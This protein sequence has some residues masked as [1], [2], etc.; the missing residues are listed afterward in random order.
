MLGLVCT[1]SLGAQL[2]GP[3]VE[4][5]A[6]GVGV[7]QKN[8]GP[9][10][11]FRG[12][13]NHGYAVTGWLYA[14]VGLGMEYRN[15]VVNDAEP[16]SANPAEHIY[17]RHLELNQLE[18][19]ATAAL[20]VEAGKWSLESGVAYLQ[21]LRARATLTT[22]TYTAAGNELTQPTTRTLSYRTIPPQEYDGEYYFL[23]HSRWWGTLAVNTQIAPRLVVGLGYRRNLGRTTLVHTSD[24]EC[25]RE[26]FCSRI[27]TFRREI[28]AATGTLTLSLRYSLGTR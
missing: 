27:G 3:D 23:L 18:G 7:F 10:P 22:G 11:A 8:P 12:T 17:R 16:S 20:G 2:R 14:R 5:A 13:I 15:F 25:P 6:G 9:G 24:F 28:P 19:L 26:T 1:Q 21:T 4:V